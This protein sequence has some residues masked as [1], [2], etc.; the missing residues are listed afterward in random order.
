MDPS[1]TSVVADAAVSN[2]AL[3]KIRGF[4]GTSDDS[5]IPFHNIIRDNKALMIDGAAITHK[6]R[7]SPRRVLSSFSINCDPNQIEAKFIATPND[8][9]R[10]ECTPPSSP[11][12]QHNDKEKYF[13]RLYTTPDRNEARQ[14]SI[15]HPSPYSH[16]SVNSTPTKPAISRTLST[17][18]QPSPQSPLSYTSFIR[19]ISP[20][21]FFFE[22]ESPSES[23]SPERT[24]EEVVSMPAKNYLG[25]G[26]QLFQEAFKGKKAI[27][28][29]FH[30]EDANKPRNRVA[31]HGHTH[32]HVCKEEIPFYHMRQIQRNMAPIAFEKPEGM[33]LIHLTKSSD[34]DETHGEGIKINW[35]RG[36]QVVKASE[37]NDE[38]IFSCQGPEVETPFFTE[39][40]KDVAFSISKTPA[41][42]LA[43][44]VDI[45]C[46]GSSGS[47]W[48]PSPKD[49]QSIV[50]HNADI[51]SGNAE[52]S[53]RKLL[54]QKHVTSN[55]K[56]PGGKNDSVQAE[57]N[58]LYYDSDPTHLRVQ[59]KKPRTRHAA[60]SRS[61][62][63]QQN[64]PKPANIHASDG[65]KAHNIKGDTEKNIMHLLGEFDEASAKELIDELRSMEMHVIWHPTPFVSRSKANEHQ[66]R[67]CH[68]GATPWS[69]RAATIWAENGSIVGEMVIPPKLTWS[70]KYID[71]GLKAFDLSN[72]QHDENMFRASDKP[73]L[74]QE[75]SPENFS[76][77]LLPYSVRMLDIRRVVSSSQYKNK[78]DK[79]LYPF[80]RNDRCFT[81]YMNNGEKYV[82]ESKNKSQRDIL[83]QGIKLFVARLASMIMIDHE[84]TCEE[85]FTV[86]T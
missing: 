4:S 18:L 16:S 37:S 47:Y 1:P 72:F 17:E 38:S 80:A 64:C 30:P 52:S 70:L 27:S 32:P 77:S 5:Y 41:Q 61:S 60:F 81:V 62:K 26:V 78:L 86:T 29:E 59:S 35:R 75:V 48:C 45:A 66:L 9:F 51:K 10:N 24:G 55:L 53:V 69:P 14:R 33:R 34:E 39:T 42:M 13:A 57:M 8:N 67:L 31:S 84:D 11:K 74:H 2:C 40:C 73:K 49:I 56:D 68:I 58:I 22:D 15:F 21:S 63:Q 43:S 28:L 20:P 83:V 79:K 44:A 82:F 19:R 65:C 25:A 7:A 85:F 46:C 12:T 54:N 36:R 6:N 76:D 23:S 50:D 71:E 3:E